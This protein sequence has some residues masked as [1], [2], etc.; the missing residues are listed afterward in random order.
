MARKVW[1]EGVYPAER[2]ER[3]DLR[4]ARAAGSLLA[5]VLDV[6]TSR[7][8]YL[9]NNPAAPPEILTFAGANAG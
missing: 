9:F 5:R 2:S 3:Q 4:L 8:R 7:F 6:V 1:M